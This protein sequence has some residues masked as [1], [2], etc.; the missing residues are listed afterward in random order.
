MELKIIE[1]LTGGG[2]MAV[3][4]FLLY[5]FF[6]LD[7]SVQLITKEIKEIKEN[8]VSKDMCTSKDI[9]KR[10]NELEKET[11]KRSEF[12]RDFSGWRAEINRVED[13]VDQLKDLIISRG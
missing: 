10:V 5:I 8:Y 3:G 13:K 2:Y 1:L 12:Y 4:A 7:R 6:R 9:S 11:L